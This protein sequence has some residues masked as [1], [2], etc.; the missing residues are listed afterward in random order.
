M[1]ISTRHV[2]SRIVGLSI[3]AVVAG[4]CAGEIDFDTPMAEEGSELFALSSSLWPAKAGV[5][6]VPLKVC[7]EGTL[8]SAADRGVVS[9]AVENTWDDNSWVDF[10]FGAACQGGEQIR[11]VSE[12]TVGPPHTNG[13]GTG[14]GKV[15]L[16]FTFL[17]WDGIGDPAKAAD[18]TC[19]TAAN[20]E[21]CMR[22]IAVHEFGHV[23]GLAHEQ[24]RT[25]FGLCADG[26]T[27][28]LQG[29]NGDL[30]IFAPDSSSIMSYCPE[31]Q[32]DGTLSSA[33]IDHIQRLY[34]G[35]GKPV[36]S[37]EYYAVR[38]PSNGLDNGKY[39]WM[40]GP[41]LPGTAGLP[42]TSVR[43]QESDGKRNLVRLRRQSG[44]GTLRYGDRVSVHDNR[45][46]L[47]YCVTVNSVSGIVQ[48]SGERNECF[49]SLDHSVGTAGGTTLNV[50][51]PFVL[52]WPTV[53]NGQSMFLG[54]IGGRMELR[55]LG[56]FPRTP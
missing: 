26:S 55:A 24:N 3:F 38:I 7:F 40:Q 6:R 32:G 48:I 9:A 27:A 5:N 46:G 21:R 30:P 16:N 44:T 22:I 54:T 56:S 28:K 37:G 33:D 43:I 8:P 14:F 47:Y 11:I 41:L 12:D 10:T 49:W 45:A 20:R 1:L 4:G 2:V 25:D 29:S 23:L 18:G 17:K 36:T 34:G 19:A 51:D 31:G 42:N 52:A 39:I 15:F 35:E 13:L 53:V 50:N